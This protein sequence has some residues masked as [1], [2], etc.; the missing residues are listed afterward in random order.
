MKRAFATAAK[1]RVAFL[2]VGNMG[3]SMVLNLQKN[4][5]E[6]KAY[7][8]FPAARK[9]AEE[10]GV[11]VADSLEEC[12]KDVDFCV[13]ALP[14]TAHVQEAMGTAFANAA[15]GTMFLDASTILPKVSIELAEIAEANGMVFMDTPM[16]GGILGAKMGTLSF[17]CGGSDANLATA[18]PV[19]QGMG[20]NIFHCGDRG[21]GG[22]AKL[23]NNLILGL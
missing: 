22:V 15:P 14:M 13:S 19:L 8:V 12:V 2:G 21:Q 10:S 4:G 20:K 23:T 7:D 16:S 11:Y 5:F 3:K 9:A 17:M 6:V 18:M 1:N